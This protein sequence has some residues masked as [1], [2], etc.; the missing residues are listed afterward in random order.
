MYDRHAKTTPGG[1]GSPYRTCGSLGKDG[2]TAGINAD[3][4]EK[5]TA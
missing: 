5:E 3:V 1:S 2:E 4:G